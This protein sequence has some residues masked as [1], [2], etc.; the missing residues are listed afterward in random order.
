VTIC[1]QPGPDR[2]I[3]LADLKKKRFV[4][5]RYRNSRIGESLK[6]FDPVEGRGTGIPKIMRA[7]KKNRSPEPRFKT[8]AHRTFFAVTFPVHPKAQVSLA[9]ANVT[10]PVTPPVA[11]LLETLASNG[12]MGNS[13]IRKRFG[14]KDRAH[15]REYYVDPALA[16]GFIEITIP[17]KPDS[18]L[19]KY[20]LTAKGQAAIKASGHNVLGKVTCRRSKA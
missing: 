8:D 13:E 16:A 14:L 20:R 1:S 18:R 12:S 17:T 4:S 3:P 9:M 7:I 10:P 15:L 5:R 2:L 11:Q 6:E 19:Q